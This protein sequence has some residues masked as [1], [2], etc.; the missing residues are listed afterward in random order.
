M[1]NS[2]ILHFRANDPNVSTSGAHQGKELQA[3]QNYVNDD[4]DCIYEYWAIA[5]SSIS[6][7]VE[8]EH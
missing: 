3:N 5:S 1:D 7:D 6:V 2:T 8:E 4:P